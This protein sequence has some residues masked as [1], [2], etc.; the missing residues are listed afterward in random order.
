MSGLAITGVETK[1]TV[2]D[3]AVHGIKIRQFRDK[4]VVPR[5]VPALAGIMVRSG[6]SVF[7]NSLNNL[8]RGVCERVFVVKGS[9]GSLGKAPV[10][11]QAGLTAVRPWFQSLVTFLPE[12]TPISMRAFVAGYRGRRGEM[13]RKALERIESG[14]FDPRRIAEVGTFVK[15]EKIDFAEKP[16]AVPRVIQ[17]RSPM[18][19]I[20]FGRYLKPMEAPLY[21]ALNKMY[22]S[23][24][25]VVMKGMT[26]DEVAGH[27]AAK[28]DSFADPVAVDLDASRFDQHVSQAMLELEHSVYVGGVSQYNKGKLAALCRRQLVNVCMGR[29]KDGMVTYKI[30]G[31]RMSGDMNTSVGNVIIMVCCLKAFI[32]SLGVRVELVNNGDDSVLILE[33]QHYALLSGLDVFMRSVGFSMKIG[34]PVE[35]LERVEFCQTRPVW[36]GDRYLMVRNPAVVMRKDSIC[37]LPLTTTDLFKAWLR[38]VGV[39]GLNLYGDVPVL[40]AFYSRM[41]REG[42]TKR[43]IKHHSHQPQMG[44]SGRSSVAG[45]SICPYARV[46]FWKAFGVLPDMQVAIET[47]LTNMPSAGAALAPDASYICNYIKDTRC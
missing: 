21:K 45:Q 12:T 24:T 36:V 18:F 20:M 27:V 26:L 46:S 8:V 13:Y 37:V 44:Y 29:A 10:P 30:H 33:R 34:P 28:W 39:C 6:Y 32:H 41:H 5:V 4:M 25:P 2:V 22:G 40:G 38:D 23:R 7:N 31:C 47:E 9:D 43:I 3:P 19:N 17:P 15:C 11:T 1:P 35:T 42:N 16:D 14:Q